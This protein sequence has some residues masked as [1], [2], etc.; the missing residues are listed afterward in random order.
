MFVTL[1]PV[2]LREQRETLV[3]FCRARKHN[4][5]QRVFARSTVLTRRKS[6]AHLCA[7]LSAQ[8]VRICLDRQL[9]CILFNEIFL[10]TVFFVCLFKNRNNKH[11]IL[12][13][14]DWKSDQNGFNDFFFTKFL[15]SDF[16]IFIFFSILDAK[17]RNK[18]MLR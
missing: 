4:R 12:N 5:L 18:K 15:L 16:Q 7:P 2:M 8:F 11:T 1:P 10:Y 17:I 13:R 3:Q 14:M 6:S 9:K